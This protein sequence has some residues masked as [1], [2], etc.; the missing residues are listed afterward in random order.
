MGA[1]KWLVFDEAVPARM[2]L[3]GD[4]WANAEEKELAAHTAGE[5][6]ALR[7]EAI[8]TSKAGLV[9]QSATAFDQQFYHR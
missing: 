8:S 6:T 4:W 1:A 9:C 7:R 2:D 3:T 5:Y